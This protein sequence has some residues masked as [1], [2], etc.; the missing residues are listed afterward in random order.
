ME[1]DRQ[2]EIGGSVH[3]MVAARKKGIKVIIDDLKQRVKEEIEKE[4]NNLDILEEEKEDMDREIKTLSEKLKNGEKKVNQKQKEKKEQKLETDRQ[5]YLETFQA[6]FR[7]QFEITLIE[8]QIAFG[9]TKISFKYH[10][11]GSLGFSINDYFKRHDEEE[12]SYEKIR[13]MFG[14]MPTNLY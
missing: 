6:L 4:E 9:R 3:E 8:H 12:E 10:L 2:I 1:T 13:R 5:E 7:K 14:K 11:L